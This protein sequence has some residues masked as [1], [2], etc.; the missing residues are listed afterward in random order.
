MRSGLTESEAQDISRKLV[1]ALIYLHDHSII[2]R[3]LKL[4]NVLIKKDSNKQLTV[5]I[6]DFGFSLLFPTTLLSTNRPVLK[7]DACGTFIYV[8]PEVLTREEF[9]FESDWYSLGTSHLSPRLVIVLLLAVI[10][11]LTLLCFLF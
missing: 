9:S 8:A 7:K 11:L 1:N 10:S 5:K 6:C 3:D 4:E 2:H